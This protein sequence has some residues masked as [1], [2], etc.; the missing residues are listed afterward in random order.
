MGV[1]DE[2]L[3]L[4]LPLDVEPLEPEELPD[5]PDVE[6]DEPDVAPVQP[7]AINTAPKMKIRMVGWVL[8]VASKLQETA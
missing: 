7:L 2:P 4:P 8:R 1:T 3:V 5:V 6:V